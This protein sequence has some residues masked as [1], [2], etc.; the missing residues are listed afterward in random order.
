MF[1]SPDRPDQINW[2]LKQIFFHKEDVVTTRFN[3]S[4]EITDINNFWT[5]IAQGTKRTYKA[6]QAN[7]PNN[8][9]C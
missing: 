6:N 8:E 4:N 3:A 2:G 5:N 7:K 1:A 9:Y